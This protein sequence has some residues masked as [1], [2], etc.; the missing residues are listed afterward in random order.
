MTSP[1]MPGEEGG[2][3]QGAHP[4]ASTPMETG[5]AGDCRSWAE[6]TEA[7]NEEEW[8]RGRP[9]KHHQ[10]S[11]RKWEGRSTNPFPLQ[12]SKGRYEVV[13]QLYQHTGERPPARHD[14]AAQGMAHHHPDLELGMAK[15]LNNQV[16]C[17]ILEYHLM[18]LSQGPSYISPVLL[19]AAKDLLPPIEEYMAGGGFQG[20]QDLR[21]LEK[22]K[23]LWVAVCLHRL[24]MAAAGDGVASFSL[25]VAQHG[26]GSLLKFLLAPQASNLTF[27]EVIDWVLI[28]NWYKIESS[29]DNVWELRTQLRRELE[30]LSGACKDEPGKSTQK[31]LKRDLEQRQKDLKGLEATISQY[32]C[33][34]GAVWVQPEGTL[35]SEDDPSNSRAEDTQELEM[36]TTPVADD[37]PTVSATPGPLTS[38]PGEEQTRCMEVDDGDDHQPPASPISHPEDEL[39]TSDNAVG[40][41]GEMANLTVSSPRGQDGGYKG[42]SI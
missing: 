40:V 28:E 41:E 13:E 24:D 23:T 36:A 11:S 33:S 5:G 42:A 30:D 39:L 7:S 14:V 27:E 25:E 20:T 37:A 15:S 35:A 18:C 29:L 2:V 10:S 17:M 9:T 1:H 26:R 34:L 32:E 16:L 12:D 38:P 3:T 22:A 6:Q 8:R 4:Y 31:K 19:E 21:V